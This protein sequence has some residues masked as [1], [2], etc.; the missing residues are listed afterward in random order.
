MKRLKSS[1][2]V[3]QM[4]VVFLLLNCSMSRSNSVKDIRVRKIVNEIKIEGI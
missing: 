1:Y 3:R 2:K 4:F